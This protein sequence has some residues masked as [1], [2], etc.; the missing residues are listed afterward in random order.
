MNRC[1]ALTW[2]GTQCVCKCQNMFCVKHDGNPSS[3]PNGTIYAPNLQYDFSEGTPRRIKNDYLMKD[4]VMGVID[5]YKMNMEEFIVFGDND[6]KIKKNI[7]SKKKLKF[8]K[9]IP[10]KI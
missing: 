7:T 8:T 3:H 6:E 10:K 1:I 5:T 9:K 4:I 2:S